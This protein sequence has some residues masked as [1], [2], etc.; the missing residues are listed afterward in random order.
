MGKTIL[1]R[2]I[3]V[4]TCDWCLLPFEHEGLSMQCYLHGDEMYDLYYCCADHLLKYLHT[5][6][7]MWG[8]RDHQICISMDG[9]QLQEL[10]EKL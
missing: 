4:T 3:S 1:Q 6:G 7:I 5:E 2:E 10:L 8:S 9:F